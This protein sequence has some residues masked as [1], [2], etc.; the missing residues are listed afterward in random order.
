MNKRLEQLA[1]K[2][3]AL[4]RAA[5]WGVTALSFF[6][7]YFLVIEPALDA[8]TTYNNKADTL[9][10]ALDNA[11]NRAEGADGLSA[12][13]KLGTT[14][15][16]EKVFPADN[17]GSGP[18]NKRIADILGEHGVTAWKSDERPA[19][20]LGNNAFQNALNPG[21]RARK[22]VVNLDF[23]SHPLT[24]SQV[25][26]DLERAPEVHAISSLV[27]RKVDNPDRNTLRTNMSVETW[28]ISEG[29]TR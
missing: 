16:G 15:F 7:A 3:S 8:T 27:L 5:R 22:I 26:A 12:D 6:L 1:T 13:L 28:V 11:A 23:E 19:S 25:L 17:P 24:A 20:N 9:R 29:R 10:T 21:Q 2:F 14:R 18:L 4:P